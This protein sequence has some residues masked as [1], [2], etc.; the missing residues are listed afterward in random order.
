MFCFLPSPKNTMKKVNM[1]QHNA[2]LP[3][4]MFFVL[5]YTKN[6]LKKL[7]MFQHDDTN[8]SLFWCSPNM[9]VTILSNS[10]FV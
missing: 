9:D 3:Y 1:F 2:K 4:L 6:T 7:N 8:R 5:L 10:V